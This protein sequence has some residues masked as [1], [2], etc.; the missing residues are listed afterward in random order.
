MIFIYL[1]GTPKFGLC[2]LKGNELTMVAY[3]DVY[4]EGIIDN[5]K[6]TSGA[7][8]YLGDCLVSWLSKK[9]SSE[10]LSTTKA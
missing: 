10:S 1:K 4:W 3:T 6:S 2:Y 9:Q 7:T 5:K 8:L